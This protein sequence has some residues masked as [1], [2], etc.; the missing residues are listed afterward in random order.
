M[1]KAPKPDSARKP[2]VPSESRPAPESSSPAPATRSPASSLRGAQPRADGG[3]LVGGLRL[4]L[5]ALLDDDGGKEERGR[6]RQH[7]QG[8]SGEEEHAPAEDEQAEPD[9]DAPAYGPSVRLDIEAE[10]GF[11]VGVPTPQGTAVPTKDFRQHVFGVCL[12]NDWS[13]RDIQG[14]EYQ[15]LGPFLAKSFATSM[16]GTQGGL[17]RA[18]TPSWLPAPPSSV[19]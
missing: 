14:W 7:A 18:A 10:V 4:A 6:R 12:V 8:V 17:S 16:A 11:V 5:G 3:A 15:P 13:A 19:T 9:A 1:P 2:P